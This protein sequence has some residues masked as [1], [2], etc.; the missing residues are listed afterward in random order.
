MLKHGRHC[1][2]TFSSNLIIIILFCVQADVGMMHAA[3]ENAKIAEDYM[4]F[5]RIKRDAL[6][7]GRK[8]LQKIG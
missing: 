3:M 5:G 7:E 8:I 2:T 6:I 4:P 1:N